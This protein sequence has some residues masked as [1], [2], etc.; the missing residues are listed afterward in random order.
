MID[1]FV[2]IITPCY[3]GGKYISETIESVI[4]QRHK[5]WE[6]LIVDDGSK[7]ESEKIIRRYVNMDP[8]IRYIYQENA[9]SAAAR[10]HGIKE[11]KGRYIA[12]LDADDLWDENFLSEQLKFM[13]K[14]KAICVCCSYR[15]IDEGSNILSK[16]TKSKAVITVDDMMVRNYIGCLTGLYDVQRYGKIYLR[17]ELKS[18]RDDYAYWL[19]IVK[20]EGK[21][22]GNDKVLAS[23]RVMSSTTTGNKYKLLGKQYAFYRNYLK[24]SRIRSIRNVLLWGWDGLC[25]FGAKK[26]LLQKK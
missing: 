2:S 6:M 1:N 16:T 21:A 14:K 10:N 17:E 3:N 13:K 12:L 24:L 8:R 20:L 26:S 4:R 23:Y 5:D 25:R 19:D 9:G 11:A 7:D 18:I 22:Y 15:M